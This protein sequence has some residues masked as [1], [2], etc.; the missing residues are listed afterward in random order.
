MKATLKN[1]AMVV[2]SAGLVGI[3]AG[4]ALFLCASVAHA[5]EPAYH[6][7]QKAD[8]LSGFPSGSQHMEDMAL[9]ILH[10]KGRVK[11]LEVWNLLPKDVGE[12]KRI[13]YWGDLLGFVKDKRLVASFNFSPEGR[14]SE[15]LWQEQGM[16][17]PPNIKWS[18]LYNA[19]GLLSERQAVFV[20]F[21]P[22]QVKW[23]PETGRKWLTQFTYDEAK[24]LI[25]RDAI[26]VYSGGATE[27]ERVL[28]SKMKYEYP[29][30]GVRVAKQYAGDGGYVQKHMLQINANGEKM[31][32]KTYQV[33]RLD[34]D[35]Y[36]ENLGRIDML[37]W[38]DNQEN[39]IAKYD[40]YSYIEYDRDSNGFVVDERKFPIISMDA[41]SM[42]V[43]END[44]RGNPISAQHYDLAQRITADITDKIRIGL[45]SHPLAA[46]SLPPIPAEL[47]KRGVLQGRSKRRINYDQAGNWTRIEEFSEQDKFGEKIYL[48]V[49]IYEQRI[50]YYGVLNSLQS[51]EQHFTPNQKENLASE[52]NPDV[53]P[54]SLATDL[55]MYQR[56]QFPKGK[57][58][59]VPELETLVNQAL[60][61]AWLYGSFTFKRSSDFNYIFH[62]YMKPIGL[63]IVDNFLKEGDT[64]V[65]ILFPLG[66][67][68][69]LAAGKL[70]DVQKDEPLE[71][72]GV[73]K[74]SD[75][76]LVVRARCRLQYDQK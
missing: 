31:S 17:F 7:F 42:V 44:S 24:N 27:G 18:F 72:L 8:L 32:E 1:L 28:E 63:S 36:A 5:I 73:T 37:K 26:T 76:H 74:A 61:N 15:M 11:S 53:K 38:Y 52:P 65:Q 21:D 14:I 67:P 23:T 16:L 6:G 60:S 4:S 40:G 25:V 71:L 62:S 75:G 2:T 47:R 45:F 13:E 66:A 64:E 70:V 20:E 39:V 58:Y 34:A 50:T 55:P 56:G 30:P 69:D 29:E 43:Y 3:G 22:K 33:S 19:D 46:H 59:S 10:T 41:G 51:L 12:A 9:E 35:H 49:V 68:R 57:L 48:P 54:R